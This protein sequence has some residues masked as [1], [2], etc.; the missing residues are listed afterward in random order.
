M[1]GSEEEG[2]EKRRDTMSDVDCAL[3]IASEDWSALK[4]D[5]RDP[6]QDWSTLKDDS[7]ESIRSVTKT[8]HFK[9]A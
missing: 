8:D 3:I 6:S 5:S 2:M 9:H 4:Q 1:F 7:G